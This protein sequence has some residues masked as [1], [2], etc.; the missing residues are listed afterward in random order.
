MGMI[1]T[2]Q[3]KFTHKCYEVKKMLV[4]VVSAVHFCTKLTVFPNEWYI[5]PVGC[6]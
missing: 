6:I 3:C 4:V 5:L 1:H 2:A